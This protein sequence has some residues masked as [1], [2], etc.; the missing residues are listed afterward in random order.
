MAK[1][2]AFEKYAAEYDE[3]FVKNNQIFL[4]E[5]DAVSTFV[6]SSRNGLEVGVGS[7]RFA[8]LLDIKTGVEP[9]RRLAQLAK[10]RSITVYENVAE[11]LPFD[12]GSFDY[13]VMVTVLCFLDDIGS[14]LKEAYRVLK[15]KGQ[16]IVAFIDK[17][18]TIGKKYCENKNQSRF[19]KEATFYTV[20]EVTAFLQNAGFGS[21]EFKQTLFSEDN[22][23]FHPVKEGYGAGSFIVVNAVR[24]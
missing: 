1:V 23:A 18:S 7:G 2:E 11:D 24:C 10:K 17:N 12:D 20:S 13:I 21:F 14:A 15:D 5:L 19:F 6:P 4:S 8:F 22:T 3:W 16:I 9:C